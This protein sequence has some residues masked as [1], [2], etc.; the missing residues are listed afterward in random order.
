M[1]PGKGEG[2]DHEKKQ[3]HDDQVHSSFKVKW[4]AEE[5]IPVHRREKKPGRRKPGQ[6]SAV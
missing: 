5:E 2:D 3:E 4:I 6:Q 1:L